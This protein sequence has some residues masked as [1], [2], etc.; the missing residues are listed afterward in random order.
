MHLSPVFASLLTLLPLTNALI[1]TMW[2][3]SNVP[4]SGL[5]DITFP[6]TII[7]ADRMRGYYFAQQFSFVNSDMGYTGLQPRPDAADG[8]PVMHAAFSSFIA[9]TTSDDPNCS[10]GADGGA[11]VS[12]A[13]D[14][15]GVYGRTYNLEVATMGTWSTLWVGTAVDTETGERI[16]IGSYTL[17]AGTGG[18]EGSQE[19]FVEWF[20]WN[21]EEPADHCA[22]LPYQQT[23]FGH[24]ITTLEGSVG[25]QSVA[26]EYGDCLGGVAFGSQASNV[27]GVE[28]HCG[29]RGM[30]G[31]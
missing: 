16:H 31:V 2:E 15:P 11:G 22:L 30:T 19:G 8:T 20:P 27:V 26:F 6:I 3:M 14:W 4:E 12:C 21:V 7:E 1:G 18:I 5:T 23:V 17:P 9:G 24:P 10:D 29:F 25:T 28:T 13:V